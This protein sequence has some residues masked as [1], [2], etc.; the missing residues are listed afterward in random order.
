M[1]QV[2]GTLIAVTAMLPVVCAANPALAQRGGLSLV[3]DAEIE[4]LL[5]DYTQPI[6][7]AAGLG[8]GQLTSI[9]S[10]MTG[11]TPSLPA[12]ACSSIPVH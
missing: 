2:R 10:M 8:K 7:K 4:G 3:R 12:G 11:S 5:R 1:A 6:F 9:S